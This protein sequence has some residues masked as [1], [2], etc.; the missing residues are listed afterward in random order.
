MSRAAPPDGLFD[1]FKFLCKKYG[2]DP[3]SVFLEYS[4]RPPPPIKG[5]RRG[6]YDGLLSFRQKGGRPEFM[7]PVFEVAR[8][9]LLTLAHE[10]AHLVNDLKTGDFDRELGPPD[11]SAEQAFDSQA[12]RDLADFEL[13]RAG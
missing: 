4:S 6:Y 2:V 5:A 9:P 13:S 10:F 8:N 11:D 3:S 7:I 1:L 12:L